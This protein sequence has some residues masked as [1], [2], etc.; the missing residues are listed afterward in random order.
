MERL[1]KKT[2]LKGQRSRSNVVY[3]EALWSLKS[4]LKKSDNLD[5]HLGWLL[6]RL[7]PKALEVRSLSRLH[8]VALFCGF[9][10]VDGQGG[11]V[12]NGVM[13]ARLAEFGVPLG[14]DLYPAQPIDEE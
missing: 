2:R 3:R 13:L 9:A 7:E 1:L 8:R 11:F 4:P 6:D 10:S 5:K 12:L 14:L